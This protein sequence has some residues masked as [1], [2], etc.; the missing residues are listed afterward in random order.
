MLHARIYHAAL[1][2]I[3]LSI[4][5][6][7]DTMIILLI[8][9]A[10]LHTGLAAIAGYEELEK[11]LITKLGKNYTINLLLQLLIKACLKRNKFI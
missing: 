2:F 9:L 11:N 4:V 10:T 6:N 1:I 3:Y 5:L 8:L 7:L